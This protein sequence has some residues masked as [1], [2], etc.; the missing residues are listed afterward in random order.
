MAVLKRMQIQKHLRGG[1]VRRSMHLCICDIRRSNNALY[2]TS[3]TYHRI[4]NKLLRTLQAI[5]DVDVLNVNG[6]YACRMETY[7]G[8]LPLVGISAGVSAAVFG[9]PQELASSWDLE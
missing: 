8:E 5:R 3:H 2:D 9:F 4:M 7:A 6:R 1:T